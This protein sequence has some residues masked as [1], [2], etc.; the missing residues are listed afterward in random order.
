[1]NQHQREGKFSGSLYGGELG[2]GVHKLVKGNIV[3]YI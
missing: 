2:D 1:M 3:M